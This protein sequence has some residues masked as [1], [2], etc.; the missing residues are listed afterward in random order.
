MPAKLDRCVA[1]VKAKGGDVDNAY[2]VCKASLGE[3]GKSEA[4]LTAAE[5][6]TVNEAFK[7][8]G[9]SVRIEATSSGSV[10]ALL[11]ASA[12]KGRGRFAEVAGSIGS[13]VGQDV[14]VVVIEGGPG[15]LGDRHW[16]TDQAVE[17]GVLVFNGAKAFLNHASGQQMFD[18]PERTVEEEIGYY[19]SLRTE[20]GAK[21]RKILAGKLRLVAAESDRMKHLR[22]LLGEAKGYA[23]RFPDKV[24]FGI[25]INADGKDQPG[26]IDGEPW[27][28][29]SEFTEAFSADVVT[30]PAAGGEF[31]GQLE[32][33]REGMRRA[34]KREAVAMKKILKAAQD[35]AE[36]MNTAK[37][38]ESRAEASTTLK[39]ALMAMEFAMPDEDPEKVGKPTPGADEGAPVETQP[40]AEAA[41]EAEDE[42]AAK[43]KA[44]ISAKQGELR[45][46][47]RTV[48]KDKPA[49]AKS[50]EAQAVALDGQLIDFSK[51]RAAKR[52]AEGEKR[53][54][55]TKLALMK[56]RD[57]AIRLLSESKLPPNVLSAELLVGH[58]EADMRATIADRKALLETVRA[59]V[60]PLRSIVEGSGERVSLE[61]D[62]SPGSSIDAAKAAG[63]P[64]ASLPEKK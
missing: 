57:L 39:A 1:Q 18:Q 3:S 24:L 29:V 4:D 22:A 31:R 50:L 15:N 60:A 35:A 19:H 62:R 5:V 16:Y 56:S 48:E 10:G 61:G 20:V 12:R 53:D 14:D 27:N 45:E 64:M 59:E 7:A 34:N 17:S 54:A 49:L 58:T 30:F 46:A 13:V 25:S 42:E 63:L 23:E 51:I 44:S 38:D 28:V 21:G 9:M 41:N 40:R 43:L 37:D 6:Q 32:A 47:A 55:E 11:R 52:K 26:E 2:A 36:A 33:L 8:A